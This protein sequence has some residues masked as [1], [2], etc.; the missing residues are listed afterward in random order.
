MA[1]S[2]PIR[3]RAVERSPQVYVEGP[4]GGQPGK[5]SPPGNPPVKPDPDR[6]APVEEPPRPIARFPDRFSR[7]QPGRSSAPPPRRSTCT[8]PYSPEAQRRLPAVREVGR[9]VQRRPRDEQH[10]RHHEP[11]STAAS[12]SAVNLPFPGAPCQRRDAAHH[13]RAAAGPPAFDLFCGHARR[14]RA[15]RAPH[16]GADGA[17]GGAFRTERQSGRPDLNRG[18]HRPK[19]CAL[20]GY[21]TPRGGHRV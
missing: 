4:M 18:S 10:R 6:P 1:S 2:E 13:V 11:G 7:G 3:R 17:G 12:P 5:P 9:R 16:T 19:R 14:C 15:T 8:R 21:A 20:P